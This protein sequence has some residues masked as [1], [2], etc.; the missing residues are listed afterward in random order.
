MDDIPVKN[1]SETDILKPVLTPRRSS[2]VPERT[3]HVSVLVGKYMI[4]WGG[5]NVSGAFSSRFA[6]NVIDQ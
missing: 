4:V 3:G 2:A 5:Y 1:V 6:C